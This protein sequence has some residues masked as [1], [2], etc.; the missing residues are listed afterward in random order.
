MISIISI[1]S[2]NFSERNVSEKEVTTTI[3]H[4]TAMPNLNSVIA[5]LSSKKHEV[6]AHFILDV[7]GIAY[8]L[9]DTKYK[10]WHAGVSCWKGQ[11][12]MNPYS[13]GIEI[14][15][16]G[17]GEAFTSSQYHNLIELLNYL[18]ET[19]PSLKKEN[20]IAHSDVAPLRKK[21]PGEMFNWQLLHKNGYGVWHNAPYTP[22]ESL[23][24]LG[25]QSPEIVKLRQN[26]SKFGYH[27]NDLEDD[28]FDHQ[29]S[30]VI[31]A[32]KRHFFPQCFYWSKKHILNHWDSYSDKILKK[33]LS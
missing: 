13:I 25:D 8:Q 18:H 23:F 17:R 4:Y 30:Q 12:N 24:S 21:D 33:L 22:A 10:A 7:D 11:K 3:L 2:P 28:I 1:P 15:N 27:L 6:S 19:V 32:F 14:I 31:V 9:V 29:L 16:H 26:L 20:V 5:R